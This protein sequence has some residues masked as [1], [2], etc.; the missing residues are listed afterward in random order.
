[1]LYYYLMKC[2]YCNQ[3]KSEVINSRGIKGNS[4]VWRRRSCLNCKKIFTTKES[5]I[6]DNL[7]VL[8]RNGSR[9]RFIYEKIFTSIFKVINTGKNRDSGDDAKLA[10]KIS[11]H[12]I[13]KLFSI[14]NNRVVS[15]KSIIE[16]VYKELKKINLSFADIYIAYSDYRIGVALSFIKKY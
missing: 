1:M 7:F 10:K 12:V 8:K 11:E 9:Q 6:A 15:S 4:M 13:E 16:L 3:E 2:I 5:P 14:S